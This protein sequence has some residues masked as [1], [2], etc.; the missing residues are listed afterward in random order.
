MTVQQQCMARNR[1]DTARCQ[2]PATKMMPTQGQIDRNP[3]DGSV[4]HLVSP[5]PTL[6]LCGFCQ[7]SLFSGSRSLYLEV[8]GG[9]RLSAYVADEDR[10]VVSEDRRF[11]LRGD[12]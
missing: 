6:R 11:S 12:Q 8:D 2:R 3:I 4:V 7:R 5:V 10:I 1:A 9:I